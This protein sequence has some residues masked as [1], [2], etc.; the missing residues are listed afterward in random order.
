LSNE[1]VTKDNNEQLL[2]EE[3][4][5]YVLEFAN[6]YGGMGRTSYLTPFLVNDRFKDITL[7][8]ISATSEKLATALKTPKSNERMLQ[9]FSQD[10]EIQSQIYKKL[11]DYQGNMLA[12]DMTYDC[13]NA[14]Y[15][16]YTSVAY[17]K[18]LD[19]LKEFIDKFDYRKE[20]SVVVKEL[21]RN[22]AYFCCPRFDG[23]QYVLQ[24]LPSAVDY[25][26]ITGRWDYGLLFSLNMYWFLLPGVDLDFYPPFFK[27]K[28]N[29]IF[30]GGKSAPIYDPSLPPQ[31]RGISSFIY[32]QDIDVNTGWAWKFNS[33][34]ATRVPLYSGLFL[35]LVQQPVIRELQKS[36]SMAVASRIIVGEIP[37]LNK[38]AATSV[39]DQFSLSAKNL[40]EFLSLVKT[41]VGDALKVA[42]VP[43]QNM[44]GI[45]FSAENDVYNSY[46]KTALASSGVNT[47]LIFTSDVR[48]NS[49]ES[50]LSLNV[51]ENQMTCL[52]SDFEKFI[53]YQVNKD[54]KKY[55]F[56]VRFEGTKFYNDRERRFDTCMSLADKGI[57]LPQEIGASIGLNPFEFQ[58]RLDEGRASGFVDNLTPI[59]SGF[60]MSSKN[61]GRPT[62][63]DGDLSSSE[64]R[65]SGA[66][67]ERGAKK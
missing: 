65:D 24:E 8:P 35:D 33:L 60:Q 42:A 9:G 67:I 63:S 43:L 10:F 46:L 37:L 66:N 34:S 31:D 55:K 27:K 40:G 59:I 13:I 62:K 38:T 14:N 58:R 22:E 19:I 39:K 48:P 7:N 47:N 52:Y 32:W 21:I 12:W 6:A 41:A 54:T 44:T 53:N 15:K 1:E 29:E 50:Q 18:D 51:D 28:Y 4:V 64:T 2:T 30:K 20:F 61:S 5:Q 26:M 11:L 17:N 36:I 25:T 57:V 3:Q 49:I 23:N 45:E 16:D 56:K